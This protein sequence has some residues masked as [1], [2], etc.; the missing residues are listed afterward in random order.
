MKRSIL[1]FVVAYV[2]A[3]AVSALAGIYYPRT[4]DLPLPVLSPGS[5]APCQ[6]RNERA[7]PEFEGVCEAVQIAARAAYSTMRTQ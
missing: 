1:V 7:S 5:E 2:S 4:L 6:P 3:L